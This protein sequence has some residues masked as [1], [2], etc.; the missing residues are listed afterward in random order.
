MKYDDLE[1]TQ[2]LFDIPEDDV[3]NVIDDIDR[4]G[5]SKE[6]LTDDLTFGLSGD[7][8]VEPQRE[9]EAEIESLEEEKTEKNKSKKKQ[10]KEKQVRQEKLL[11]EI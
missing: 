10:K 9:D 1:K 7:D 4:E 8:A 2:D 11:M 5:I 6:N 3:P